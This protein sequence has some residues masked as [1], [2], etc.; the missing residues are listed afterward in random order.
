MGDITARVGEGRGGSRGDGGDGGVGS[1]GGS[2]GGCGGD[3]GGTGWGR[4]VEIFTFNVVVSV[5]LS[6]ALC[7]RIE[8]E[9]G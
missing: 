4:D 9:K 1:G 6:A 8:Q 7:L 3:G 5:R 2:G